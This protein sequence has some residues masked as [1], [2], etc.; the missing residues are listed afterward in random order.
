MIMSHTHFHT[1]VGKIIIVAV[2]GHVGL[3]P[4]A[5]NV[6]GGFRAQ[7]RTAIRAKTLLEEA[8]RLQDAGV[9]AIVLECIPANVA[10]AITTQLDIPTIGIG[11]GGH[12]SGQVLV[13]HDLLGMSSH[14][15]HEEFVPKFC[16]RYASVGLQINDGLAQ[17][18]KEVDDGI[19]PGNDYSPY[20]MSTD[21]IVTFDNLLLTMDQH[22]KINRL[23]GDRDDDGMVDSNS[24]TLYGNK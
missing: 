7:G 20:V 18:K 16:K 1:H 6:L 19:F 11:A 9:F 2:M 23:D 5:I 4:Q 8:L 12:T 22:N 15:H 3:T 17:F 24:E 14:P 21:E 13:F 10:H